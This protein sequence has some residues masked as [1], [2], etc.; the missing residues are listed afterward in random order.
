M[1]PKYSFI[2]QLYFSVFFVGFH[3]VQEKHQCVQESRLQ[4]PDMYSKEAGPCVT[5]AEEEIRKALKK[6]IAHR[7]QLQVR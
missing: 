6:T 5:H 3:D 7:L 1:W 2:S 4:E